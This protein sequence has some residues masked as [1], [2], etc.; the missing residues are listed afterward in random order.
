[1]RMRLY[2]LDSLW[3][4]QQIISEWISLIWVER[5]QDIGQIQLQVV[6]N[7]RNRSLLVEDS[8]LAM[9]KSLRV[10][11]IESVE[12]DASG[13]QRLLTIK[14]TSYESILEARAAKESTDDLTTSPTWIITNP[15]ADVA[16][17]LFSDI[18]VTGVL[19]PGDII[20]GISTDTWPVASTIPEPAADITTAF[21]PT[22][23][24]DALVTQTCVTYDLGFRFVRDDV[25]STLYFNVYTGDDRTVGNSLFPPVL[26]SPTLGNLQ[27]TKELTTIDEARNVAYVY[28][29]AGFAMVYPTGID[30]ST[31]GL[32]RRVL[33]VDGSSVTSDNPDVPGAL[34]QLGNEALA[35][36]RAQNSFD[37]QI[38]PNSG[39]EYGV[40]YF[41]GDLVSSMNVDAVGNVMRVTEQIFSSDG[42]YG[43]TSYPTLSIVEYI[44]AGTWK[45]YS[46]SPKTWSDFA[47]DPQTWSDQP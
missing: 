5:W 11:R 28:S 7:Y 3:R 20:A 27:N 36:A 45:S 39:Y 2:T 9:N 15:P 35:A 37:G 41:L 1:M 22:T 23:L 4:R 16:R 19:D 40:D 32:Q 21:T 30:P 10:M 17:Q 33:V 47:S 26:F 24:Y 18:C 8:Y 34:T 44:N 14:G 42:V 29:P 31:A 46:A 25:T 13:D 38:S 12:D 43:E 6:S